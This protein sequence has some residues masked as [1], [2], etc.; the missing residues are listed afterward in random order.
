MFFLA[1]VFGRRQ[2]NPVR[3]NKP[4]E[5]LEDR[6]MLSV[7]GGS[8]GSAVV[9][10]TPPIVV[11]PLQSPIT[12]LTVHAVDG[13]P[14]SGAVGIWMTKAFPKAGSSLKALATISWGD[15]TSSA[16]TFVADG[17]GVVQ[18]DGAH[19][20]TKPGTFNT[21]INVSEI[22][23]GKPGQPLP[24]FIVEVGQGKGKAIVAGQA[25]G[26]V[27]IYTKVGFPFEG[28][29]AHLNFHVPANTATAEYSASIDWGD[30]TQSAGTFASSTAAG[31]SDVIGSHKY[32]KAGTFDVHVVVTYGPT[33]GSGAEFPTKIV[34]VIDST[35]HVA[36]RI[37]GLNGTIAGTYKTPLTN[38]DAGATYVFTGTGKAG[39]LGPVSLSGSVSLPGFIATGSASGTLTLTTIG[40][41]P[42]AGGSVTLK[43][44]GPTEKGFGPFPSTLSFTITGGTGA[45]ANDTGSGTI[46]V[47]LDK[48]AHA[49]AFVINSLLPPAL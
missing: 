44:T 22:P 15:G 21:L 40:A 9:P 7:S 17:N 11:V 42:A 16:G 30:G 13:V 14:F 10:V 32:T 20:W 1:S 49:F 43:V 48:T 6:R 8:T 45:F 35:A 3:W 47:T 18:I 36:K 19:T 41:T 34:A 24:Q 33:P 31:K 23:V 39:A 38:P 27:Q 46:A 2:E 29:V 25:A 12:G 28:A 4:M 5:A 26:A 37:I